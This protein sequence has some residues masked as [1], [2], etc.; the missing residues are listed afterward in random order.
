MERKDLCYIK[1]YDEIKCLRKGISFL[2]DEILISSD[3]DY[4]KQLYIKIE[5]LKERIGWLLLDSGEYEKGLALYLSLPWKTHGEK[6]YSGM[7]RAFIEMQHY[8]ESIRLLRKGIR[9]FPESTMLM[10]SKGLLCQRLGLDKDAL[11]YFGKALQLDPDNP[12]ALYDKAV[13]L[14]RLS[15][16]EDAVPILQNLTENY[17]NNPTYLFEMGYCFKMMGYPEDALQYYRKAQEAGYLSPTIYE[18]LYS[19][20]MYL[21]LNNEALEVAL[22]GVKA[23]PDEPSMY[24]NLG[25]C[26]F[27]RGWIAEAKEVLKEGIKK[28]PEDARLKTLLKKIEDETDDPDKGKKPPHIGLLILLIMLLRKLKEKHSW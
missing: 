19:L 5:D 17:T 20:Y 1:S 28:F 26:Y 11:S 10:V 12:Y 2:N 24:E 23:Y 25:E 3:R 4:K 13:S 7:S 6:K 18:E 27:K 21:G 9:R 14:N 16:Y 15:Y 22:E 8:D